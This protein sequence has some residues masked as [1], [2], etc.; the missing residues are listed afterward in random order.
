MRIE[1]FV[2]AKKKSDFQ[3]V[4]AAADARADFIALFQF[5]LAHKLF[6]SGERT[7]WTKPALDIEPTRFEI[8]WIERPEWRIRK[9][10]DPKNLEIIAAKIRQENKSFHDWRGGSDPGHGSDLRQNRLRQ[11]PRRRG[12]FQLRFSGD[13]IHAR[14]ERAVRALIRDLDRE[15]NRDA[16][17]NTQDVKQAEQRMT[18]QISQDVPSKNTKI[19]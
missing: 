18:P 8:R 16:E 15:I 2:F 11:T 10:V 19:L 1:R 7:R 13:E 17:R 3:L 14:R 9:N 12:N 4:V 5:M 6:R